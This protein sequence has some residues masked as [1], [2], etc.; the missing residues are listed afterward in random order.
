M[1]V[2]V[3]LRDDWPAALREAGFDS[4]QP[5]GW[6]LEG[7]LPYLPGAAQDALFERLND[8]SAP[9]SRVAAELGPEPGELEHLAA[10]IKTVVGETSDGETQPNLR[11]LWFDDPRLDTK[12]WLGERGW[13]VTEANLVD[14][15][16][17]Y[18][19]PLHDLPPAFEIFLSTKFFTAV[20]DH[21]RG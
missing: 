14:A 12:T 17:A 2:A 3:D 11:D 15:A 20:Q 21:P 1:T 16:V 7:L 19:R 8:M 9:G 18:G 13:T 6:I 4:T 5:T 10:S